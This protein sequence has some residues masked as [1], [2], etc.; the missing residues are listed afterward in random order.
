MSTGN[1]RESP[2]SR[3]ARLLV[4]AGKTDAANRIHQRIKQKK[5]GT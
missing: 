4:R 5:D 1:F 3:A 2:E